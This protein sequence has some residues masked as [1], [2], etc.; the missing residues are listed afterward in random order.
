[1]AQNQTN[2]PSTKDNVKKGL[3]LAADIARLKFK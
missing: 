1:M 3:E 2:Q